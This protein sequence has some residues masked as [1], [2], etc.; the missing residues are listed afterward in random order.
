M[1]LV[2]GKGQSREEACPPFYGWGSKCTPPLG[3]AAVR[4]ACG[5]GWT[6]GAWRALGAGAVGSELSLAR[7]IHAGCC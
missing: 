1:V 6:C 2:L 3:F 7:Q 5:A 4:C